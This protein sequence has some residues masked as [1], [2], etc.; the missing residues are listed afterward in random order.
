MARPVRK[1]ASS[2]AGDGPWGD[3]VRHLAGVDTR[4][5]AR[6]SRIGPCLLE[7]SRDR[8][9]ILVRAIVG[10]QISAA[11]ARAIHGRLL[12]RVGGAYQ[13]ATI[14]ALG[15]APLREV[16]L[17]LKKAENVSVLADAVESGRLPLSRMG[18]WADERVIEALVE[19]PGIGRWTAEMFL[20]FSLGRPDV[21][22]VDDLGIRVG[23]QRHFELVDPPK[24]AA[25]RALAEP[26]RPFRS[27]AMWYLWRDI[28]A[29][30]AKK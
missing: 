21:L 14:S 8:F 15:I 1:T 12:E 27:I 29:D 24:P 9:G 4:W 26:W 6:I 2:A 13:P 19:M 23:I 7:P 17:S 3:A 30:R 22:A 16:G 20:V 5:R 11:A 28:E 25:C 10:Q 18:R